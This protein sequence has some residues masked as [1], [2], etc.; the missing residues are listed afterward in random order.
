[1]TICLATTV[2]AR[3]A[4][5]L[6]NELQAYFVSK[7]DA[8][9]EPVQG[10]RFNPASWLRAGGKFGGGTR[11]I[12]TDEQLFNRASVNV[13]QIQYE[14]D[15]TKKMASATALSTI[16]HPRRP[17]MPSMHM[18]IS[19]TEMK[20]GS[21]YWRVMGDL[22]PA[23]PDAD[24][25]SL[26]EQAFVD[27][28]G[29]ELCTYGMAQGAEYFYIPALK[30][31]RGVAHFYLE[32]HTSG[33]F[34]ADLTMAGR[35]GRTVIET[36]H[37]ISLSHLGSPSTLTPSDWAAQLAYHS[38]YFLQV[39]TLDRG[40]TS[41]LLVHAE[42]DVGILGSLPSH[43]DKALLRSCVPQLPKLQQTLLSNLLDVLPDAPKSLVDDAVKAK[44]A[45]VVRQFYQEH[46]EAQELMAR[47]DRLAPTQQN[48]RGAE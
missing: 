39:L 46:P 26:F 18:H 36:Y 32:A 20:D 38:I 31:H 27:A 13:S 48:H 25:K 22:N 45:T 33:V 7:L 14:N 9:P 30:R 6:V 10:S 17:D 2:T 35:F 12:A 23:L 24:D 43:V 11:F 19:W 42:N 1:M 3:R 16:V 21:G 41:G 15:A 5:D 4:Y 29:R 34:D 40:T 47:A 44:L 28:V 8:L 37:K